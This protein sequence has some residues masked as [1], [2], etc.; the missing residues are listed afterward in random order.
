MAP[1]KKIAAGK[2]V[3]KEKKVRERREKKKADAKATANAAAANAQEPTPAPSNPASTPAPGQEN[4]APP[5]PGKQY[6]V[7]YTGAKIITR[8]NSR[9]RSSPDSPVPAQAEDSHNDYSDDVDDDIDDDI[10]VTSFDHLTSLVS[11]VSILKNERLGRDA[12]DDKAEKKYNLAKRL[13]QAGTLSKKAFDVK[14]KEWET[15]LKTGIAAHEA[16]K[17]KLVNLEVRTTKP[18]LALQHTYIS[19]IK[20][21]VQSLR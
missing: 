10:D 20:P 5:Q 6:D 9:K 2:K 8:A 15:F 21:F 17:V 7:T 19:P 18:Y 4:E 11:Q 12:V 1:P 3:H 16:R 14:A 13:Y